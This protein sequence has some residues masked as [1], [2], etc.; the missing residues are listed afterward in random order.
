MLN[1][2]ELRAELG[3]TSG[4]SI[5]AETLVLMKDENAPGPAAIPR[6]ADC[7]KEFIF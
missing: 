2:T 3:T 4:T 1:P 7:T 6:A 5:V